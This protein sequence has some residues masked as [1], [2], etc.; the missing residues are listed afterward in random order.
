[1]RDTAARLDAM[2]TRYDRSLRSIPERE[3][4]EPLITG[5]WS[6]KQILGHLID[7]AVNN[8]QRFVRAAL[9]DG[10]DWPG[11]DQNGCVEIESFQD[12]PWLLL[13]EVWS[14][15]NRLLSHVLM[16]LPPEKA[17]VRCFIGG[18]ADMPLGE[19][20][21]AYTTHLE[22]HLAQLRRLSRP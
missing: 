4:G 16:H 5:G 21:R 14:G 18:E 15:L 17:A 8:H 20:A 12:A 10:L 22:H 6:A 11:Y 9:Q 7:S 3:A 2:V 1:M 13:I 19:L